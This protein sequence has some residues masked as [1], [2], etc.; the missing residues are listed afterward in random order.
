MEDQ[1]GDPAENPGLKE[2]LI[3]SYEVGCKRILVTN[4]WIPAMKRKN[5]HLVTDQVTRL[6]S[7]AVITKEL[8]LKPDVLIY[9]TGYKATELLRPVADNIQ[10]KSET[11]S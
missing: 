4:N 10:G 3:P 7:D 11:L 8:T 1:L 9:G 6:S 5:V 2:K